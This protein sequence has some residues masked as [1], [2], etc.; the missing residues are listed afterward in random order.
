[1]I[2]YAE[3]LFLENFITGLLLLLF[4]SRLAGGSGNY[5]DDGHTA[6]LP[7][8]IFGAVLSGFSAFILF[9]PL[10]PAGAYLIRGMCAFA[11]CRIGLGRPAVLKKTLIFLILSFLTGGAAMAL[12]LW[13]Q[14]PALSGNGILYLESMTY[15]SLICCG[16]PAMA[17]ACWFIRLIR[18]QRTAESFSGEAELELDRMVCR[19]RAWVDSGNELKDPVSGRPVILIDRKGRQL[20]PFRKEDYEV[21]FAAVPYRAVGTESG[22]LQGIRLD[23]VKYKGIRIKGAVL[24]FYEGE[25]DGFEILLHREMAEGGVLD[26]DKSICGN[27]ERTGEPFLHESA[28]ASEKKGTRRTLLHRR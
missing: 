18:K 15:V 25:F 7:R 27:H 10:S 24:A 3:Y 4:T 28:P 1:M 13:Q 20:L 8:F 16:A 21:R 6:K 5:A 17:G 2:V 23:S 12:F 9:L 11:I 26:D 14:I 22:I 19:M